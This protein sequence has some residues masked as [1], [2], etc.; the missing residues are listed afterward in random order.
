MNPIAPVTRLIKAIL[1]RW[2]EFRAGVVWVAGSW[3][4]PADR[5]SRWEQDNV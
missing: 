3:L 4:H 2:P 5:E 1:A